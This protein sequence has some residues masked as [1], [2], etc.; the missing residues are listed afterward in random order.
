MSLYNQTVSNTPLSLDGLISGDFNTII[1]DGVPFDPKNVV[2]Y[3]GATKSIDLNN[4]Q[5]TNASLI[6]SNSITTNTLK[7]N[8]IP[9]GTQSGMLGYDGFGNV[10]DAIVPAATVFNISTTSGAADVYP[11]FSASTSGGVRP[12]Y[13]DTTA[14]TLYYNMASKTLF[15]YK[16]QLNSLQIT[17]VPVGT[18]T[19]LLAVD[20]S[21]NVI[22][23]TVPSNTQLL[24]TAT[25]A[26]IA[27]YFPTLVTS[28]TTGNKSY[29]VENA[30]SGYPMYYLS[31]AT[32]T[33][34]TWHIPNLVADVSLVINGASFGTVPSS[35]PIGSI[36]WALGVDGSGAI[37]TYTPGNQTAITAV[38]NSNAYNLVFTN[39]NL[40]TSAAILSI[41]SGL[42]I[43]YNPATNRLTVPNLTV[44]TS[45]NI[46]DYALLASPAF[47][48][49]PTA[50]TA[51]V[52]TN[53]SQIATCSF[54]LANSSSGSY[55]PLSGGT[56]TGTISFAGGTNNLISMYQSKYVQYTNTISDSNSVNYISI[57]T[58]AL[59]ATPPL[60]GYVLIGRPLT[61]SGALT[62]NNNASATGTLTITGKITGNNGLTIT[63]GGTTY[64]NIGVSGYNSFYSDTNFYDL[65][66]HAV[67]QVSYGSG[68]N[69]NI[70]NT[71][72]YNWQTTSGTT[73]TT[74]MNLSSSILT[75][76]A[77][78]FIM[79]YATNP[80]IQIGA[81]Y[82]ALA[83]S[84]GSF[85]NDAAANDLIINSRSGNIRLGGGAQ[86]TTS[87]VVVSNTA[88]T[89][90]ISG[91]QIAAVNASGLSVNNITSS[92]TL[93]LYA[94][95]GSSV[96]VI[97]QGTNGLNIY[98]QG[99]T[100]VAQFY[101]A[102]LSPAVMVLS[103]VPSIYYT[104]AGV[105]YF[106][107]GVQCG[108][109]DTFASGWRINASNQLSIGGNGTFNNIVNPNSLST[110]AP[111]NWYGGN[112]MTTT[113]TN[114]TT[115][116][117]LGIGWSQSVGNTYIISLQPSIAWKDMW[118]SAA[119]THIFFYGTQC[120][121][122]Q[123][124]GWVNISDEREKTN[125][126]P[127]KTNRSLERVLS[128]KTFTYNR[129]FYKDDGGNDI[130]P[131]EV[132]EKSHIGIIAQQVQASNPHCLSTWKNKNANDEERYGVNYH[133][134]TVHLIGAVQELN[135][136]IEQ[137]N[138]TI[139]GLLDHITKLTEV[140]NKLSSGK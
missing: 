125:I 113:Y 107:A 30:S 66:N 84:A 49:T 67:M 72:S 34:G 87:Q 111:S 20:A 41:D 9:S 12:L 40:A 31:S 74:A 45:A 102:P 4:K 52:G 124:S 137:Q 117:G 86:Y 21:G 76:S 51:A 25:P 77:Q 32:A 75:L 132:K 22:Q 100:F 122:S 56:M 27:M 16:A 129:L 112:V 94:G 108:Y 121:Y 119:S 115:A 114:S 85:L 110:Y 7:I 138:K 48:G 118:I 104:G 92:S 59:L 64:G 134:Y 135:I 120:S 139:Q 39:N 1:I 79:N 35:L 68:V 43:T 130:V 127:L 50:P 53:T 26:T 97:G 123:G 14:G 98:S 5:L 105:N 18:Q 101:C 131:D 89:F 10:I 90:N 69:Q 71:A 73:G 96:N 38:S 19:S 70:S 88:T 23:G 99:G 61:V 83:T 65:S 46:P 80:N 60:V 126:K 55:L 62:V 78:N 33:P 140:V 136:K 17:S 15:V 28:Q 37:R 57:T 58:D 36:T 6:S 29:Y 3:T 42:D 44:G 93:S 133:D 8:T 47:T 13:T 128:A 11:I 81:N 63:S 82:F 109:W 95:S 54:V 103:G 91:T 2:P 116:A 24:T 106:M